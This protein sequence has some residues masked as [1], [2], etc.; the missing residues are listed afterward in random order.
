MLKNTLFALMRAI[1]AILAFCQQR[2]I[3]APIVA[4]VVLFHSTILGLGPKVNLWASD[5]EFC[6]KMLSHW[7]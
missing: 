4:K 7:F 1:D 5:P 3:F 2:M 6:K